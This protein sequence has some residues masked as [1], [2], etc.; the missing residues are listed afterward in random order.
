MYLV[1]LGVGT[2]TMRVLKN[3]SKEDYHSTMSEVLGTGRV[4]PLIETLGVLT[5]Q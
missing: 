5:N 3:Q 2:H 1:E 4:T